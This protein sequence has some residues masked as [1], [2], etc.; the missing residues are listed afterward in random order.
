MQPMTPELRELHDKLRSAGLALPSA[1][2]SIQTSSPVARCAASTGSAD[3]A[4][5]EHESYARA[6]IEGAEESSKDRLLLQLLMRRNSD[7]GEGREYDAGQVRWWENL[8]L[9]H[10]IT[11][12]LEKPNQSTLSREPRES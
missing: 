6:L 8:A 10:P 7:G 3:F 2:E 1:E 12:A 11:K 5:I 4:Y 9:N